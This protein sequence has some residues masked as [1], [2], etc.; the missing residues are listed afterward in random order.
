MCSNTAPRILNHFNYPLK[1]SPE[2]SEHGLENTSLNNQLQVKGNS[3][4][5]PLG[6]Q[7]SS[8]RIRISDTEIKDGRSNTRVRALEFTQL[9]MG[10]H[11]RFESSN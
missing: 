4:F 9:Y 8:L 2:K 6:K 1:H 5:T 3:C 11:F 7:H 10:S